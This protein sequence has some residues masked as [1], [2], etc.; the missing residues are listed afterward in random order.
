[1]AS[2]TDD[3]TV[4]DDGLLD[5]EPFANLGPGLRSGVDE[6]L[7]EHRTPRAIRDRRLVG[8]GGARNCE[9]SEVEG[10]RVDRRTSRR[11]QPI[12]NAPSLQC[13]DPR[14]VKD[15]RTGVETSNVESVLDRG[16]LDEFVD[17]ELRRR[18]REKK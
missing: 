15:V 12:E 13:R 8:A 5:R 16:E 6:Q 11:R 9:R 7:V 2:N 10:V 14:R 17:A 1:M 3:A 4:L 18:K